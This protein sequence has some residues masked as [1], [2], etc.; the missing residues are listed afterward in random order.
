MQ[1]KLRGCQMPRWSRRL[2]TCSCKT[3]P[4]STDHWKLTTS[5]T[6]YHRALAICSPNKSRLPERLCKYSIRSQRSI[7]HLHGQA[8]INSCPSGP[9][10]VAAIGYIEQGLCDTETHFWNGPVP[11]ADSTFWISSYDSA[12]LCTNRGPSIVQPNVAKSVFKKP[13]KSK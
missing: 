12:S 10:Q 7:R 9:K 3:F 13:R 4:T 2:G 1:T 11:A 5:I 8:I 6:I